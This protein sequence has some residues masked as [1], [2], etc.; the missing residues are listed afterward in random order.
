[1]S[2]SSKFF[3]GAIFGAAV[4]SI[5]AILF[6]PKSGEELRKDL[7]EKASRIAIEV[8]KAA[9]QRQQELEEEINSFKAKI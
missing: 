1:M 5:L 3:M 4:G 8:K 9:A 2:K 6:A 7:L